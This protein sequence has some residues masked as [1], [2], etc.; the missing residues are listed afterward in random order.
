M[1]S[2]SGSLDTS[3]NS[4]PASFTFST[5]PFMTTSFSDLLASPNDID[6]HNTTLENRNRSLSDRIAERTGSGVPKFKSIPPPL[7]IS[8]PAVS[9]SSYFAIPAGLSPAELL[10]SP[11]L[12]NTSNILPSPTTGTFPAQAFNWR[13][14]FSNQQQ[15]VKQE[16]KNYSDFS[17]QTQQR[18]P[19]S[20]TTNYQPSNTAIQTVQPQAWSFQEPTKQDDFSTGKSMVKAEFGS[21]QGYST[22]ITTITNN[23][24]SNNN[25]NNNNGGFQSEYG[26]YH[27]QPQQPQTLSRRSDDG[28]NWR[29]YGQKQVK[30][31]EN[32]RSYYKCTYPNCPTKK[33]VERSLDGQITE[34]VYKG[35]HNHPKPQSTRRSSSSSSASSHAIQVSNSSSHELHD[36]SYAI[37]GNGHTDS[38]A[39]PENSSIS[40]GDEDFDQSSQK[41][42]SAGED[43]DDDEPDAKRWKKEGEN[44]GIS[45]AGSRTVREPR[46]VVQ[47]T[48]DI[49]I[50]DDG[51]RWRK[52]GQ[53]VVKGNP[54]PRSYYKC[55]HPGCPVRKHV[56][57]ASHDLRAVITTYEGKHNHD[58]PA[59]R[60]SGSHSVN[61]PL[62][63]NNNNNISAATAIRPS[64][65]THH[66]NNSVNNHHLHNLR[67]PTSEGQAP[68]TL[69]MLQS[70]GSFGFSGFGNALG[71]YM[72]QQEVTDNVYSRAKEEPRDDM[73]FE[74]LLA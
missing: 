52:Y 65:I 57:R 66:T 17:F 29:K 1:A 15:N 2:S 63:S 30:G 5:H 27:Q 8:P 55:T 51:Y 72:N 54:N 19:L 70:P 47:T 56:E 6:D 40:M 28:Y 67:L 44:E 24:Q 53:K 23:T 62:P 13:S 14:N 69:E 73:F 58:V 10:D 39:T 37:L 64:A 59:A 3:A 41:S 60:G 25:N 34:I 4:H 61:R 71:S 36:Q 43:Y 21:M 12:L 33:K 46:V 49:D 20:S 35:S 68:F 31:S 74:S 18:P 50:L 11:V 7:P 48:S 22:D 26:N 42:K 9:P 38:V 32:P 16:N 45:A